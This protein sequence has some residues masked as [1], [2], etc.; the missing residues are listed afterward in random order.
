ME[1]RET[2]FHEFQLTR[3]F[4]ENR[5]IRRDSVSPFLSHVYV[6]LFKTLIYSHFFF[7]FL[8]ASYCRSV[9]PHDVSIVSGSFNQSFSGFFYA[10]I[11]SLYQCFNPVF[12]AGN[13]LP[14]F[15]NT[16]SVSTLFVECNALCMV[17]IFYSYA[18]S[19]YYYYYYYYYYLEFFHTDIADG[20]PWSWRD[21]NSP[22]VSWTLFSIP[23]DF[24]NAV[25]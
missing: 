22:L 8:I 12:I 13:P 3:K 19:Y 7:P 6:F 18:W 20:F 10:V 17:I 23:V 14:H 21:S 9:S 2:S 15:L 1:Q 16:Y 24:G 11:E 5:Q 25:V 4:S